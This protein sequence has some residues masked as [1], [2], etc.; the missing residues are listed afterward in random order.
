MWKK[1]CVN[2]S[3]GNYILYITHTHYVYRAVGG[4]RG[5]ASFSGGETK[6]KINPWIVLNS[7]S[8]DSLSAQDRSVAFMIA[9]CA[10][11]CS[12]ACEGEERPL[13][14]RL[15]LFTWITLAPRFST[16]V[17][18]EGEGRNVEQTSAGAYPVRWPIQRYKICIYG[19]EWASKITKFYR[20]FSWFWIILHSP[21]WPPLTPPDILPGRF[22]GIER[23]LSRVAALWSGPFYSTHGNSLDR[24]EGTKDSAWFSDGWASESKRIKDLSAK[25]GS[26]DR[27]AVKYSAALR[28]AD[29]NF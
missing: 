24:S 14:T 1:G 10:H 3:C 25:D 29:L 9:C 12:R 26:F 11:M 17:M 22:K 21:P 23:V 4:A 20:R 28:C 2:G 7:V 19:P 13:W 6:R 16:L 5:R 8:I 18:R 15:T 27:E